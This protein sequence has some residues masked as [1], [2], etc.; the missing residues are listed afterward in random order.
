MFCCGGGVSWGVTGE[1][2]DFLPYLP[3]EVAEGVG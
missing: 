2:R 1:R 3:P